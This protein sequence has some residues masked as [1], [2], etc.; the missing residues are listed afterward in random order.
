MA[1]L[2]VTKLPNN[3]LVIKQTEGY[4]FFLSSESS[5]VISIGSLSFLLQF[6]V[7]NGLMSAKV[8][9]GILEEHN[10]SR[11]ERSSV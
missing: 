3:V 11:K 5:V 7:D 6:L 9:E 2:T 8:L 1:K 4:D 10:S